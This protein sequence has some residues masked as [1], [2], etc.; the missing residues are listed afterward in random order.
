MKYSTGRV[1]NGAQVLDITI[2][3][4]TRDEFGFTDGAATFDDAS[5]GIRGRVHFVAFDDNIGAAVL[6]QYDAGA[7]VEF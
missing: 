3:D 4:A 5:R 6:A 7:Y 1:Y 2:H